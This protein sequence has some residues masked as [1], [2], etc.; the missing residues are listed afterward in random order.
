MAEQTR[1]E[2]PIQLLVEGKD[3]LNFFEAF[4]RRVELQSHMQVRNFGGVNQLRSFLLALVDSPEFETVVS[5]GIVRD[6]EDCAESARQSVTDSLRNA[7]LPAPGDALGRDDGPTVQILVLP[8]AGSEAGMLETLLCRSFAD[9]PVNDCI[10][11]FLDCA[12]ALPDVDI[13]RPDK[14]RAQAYLAT[15]PEPHVSVGVAAQKGYWP[16]DH[17][18]FVEVRKFLAGL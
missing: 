1:I 15:R 18:A 17:D 7:G 6:A 11:G 12:D 2:E 16:L 5:V 8:G 4:I 10:N 3:Q 9:K 14:A 13:R